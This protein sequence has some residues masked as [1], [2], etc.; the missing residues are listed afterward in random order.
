VQVK[1]VEVEDRHCDAS[2]RAERCFRLFHQQPCSV[3][4][5]ALSFSFGALAFF[6]IGLG[7]AQASSYPSWANSST[8]ASAA[9]QDYGSWRCGSAHQAYA[10]T[11]RQLQALKGTIAQV[12]P[13]RGGGPI[14]PVRLSEIESQATISVAQGV[15]LDFSD[16]GANIVTVETSDNPTVVQIT[17]KTNAVAVAIGRARVSVANIGRCPKPTGMQIV[18]CDPIPT[19]SVTINVQDQP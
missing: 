4:Q 17:S 11:A 15:R 18:L 1:I 3:C 7:I 6:G 5:E 19:Y 12:G 9:T 14:R 16:G 10:A 13:G 8:Q 2:W